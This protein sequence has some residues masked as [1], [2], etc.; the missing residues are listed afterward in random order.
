MEY[1][2]A[3]LELGKL[4]LKVEEFGVYDDCLLYTSYKLGKNVSSICRRKLPPAFPV[5]VHFAAGTP[6]DGAF[7][8]IE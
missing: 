8:I 2:T 5:T 7:P 6:Y 4:G 1:R 3:K